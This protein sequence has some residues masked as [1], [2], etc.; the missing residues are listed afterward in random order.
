MYA[1]GDRGFIKINSY[2]KLINQAQ[3]LVLEFDASKL[4]PS[5]A[6]EQMD[7]V[8]L[9]LANERD[10]RKIMSANV[11][12]NFKIAKILCNQLGWKL[13]FRFKNSTRYSLSIPIVS[14]RPSD[15]TDV[16]ARPAADYDMEESKDEN[17]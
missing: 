6:M 12:L 16:Q 9:N 4:L 11:D 8:R 10:V 2:R 7:L 17:G 3:S 14:Q 1:V 13:E 15:L 5:K